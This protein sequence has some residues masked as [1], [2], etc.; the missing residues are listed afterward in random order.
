MI[1]D[2]LKKNYSDYWQHPYY[3]EPI[4]NVEGFLVNHP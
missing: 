3:K 2:C 4:F 1:N